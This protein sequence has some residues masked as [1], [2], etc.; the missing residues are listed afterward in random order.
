MQWRG[1]REG[2]FNKGGR[3]RLN[4]SPTQGK[5]GGEERTKEKQAG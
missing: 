5:G 4:V 2:G 1:V 3:Y